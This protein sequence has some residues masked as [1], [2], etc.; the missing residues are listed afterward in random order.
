MNYDK[1]LTDM[2]DY[3]IP[4]ILGIFIIGAF[5]QLVHRMD[6]TFVAF[7]GTIVGAIAGHAFT[8]H[9]DDKDASNG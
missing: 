6:M 5:L 2:K 8:K 1:I 7:T 9:G 4:A 3:H